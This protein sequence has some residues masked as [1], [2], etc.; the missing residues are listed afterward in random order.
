VRLFREA[1]SATSQKLAMSWSSTA[2]DESMHEI[3]E[4]TSLHASVPAKNLI[5]FEFKETTD[6]KQSDPDS[7]ENR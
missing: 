2:G 3:G 4:Q 6:D 1:F 5:R 7:S